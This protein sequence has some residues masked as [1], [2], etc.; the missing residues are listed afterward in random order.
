MP[1]ICYS[2]DRAVTWLWLFLLALLL[3]FLSTRLVYS[4]PARDPTEIVLGAET[5]EVVRNLEPLTDKTGKQWVY[6]QPCKLPM[7]VRAKVLGFADH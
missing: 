1:T 7:F 6:G 4:E 5:T 3:L 2:Q